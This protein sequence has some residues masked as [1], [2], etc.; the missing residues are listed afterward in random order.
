MDF[1]DYLLIDII[2][3]K[4]LKAILYFLLI[5]LSLNTKTSLECNLCHHVVRAIQKGVPKRPLLPILE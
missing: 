1:M 5:C 3:M 2:S 4:A